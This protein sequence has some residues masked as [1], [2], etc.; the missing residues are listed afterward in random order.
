MYKPMKDMQ[1][2]AKFWTSMQLL[3]GNGNG[4]LCKFNEKG[5][6]NV[7]KKNSKKGGMRWTVL[8]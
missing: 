5:N 4:N 8:V 7:N 3:K 6:A 1:T 2:N